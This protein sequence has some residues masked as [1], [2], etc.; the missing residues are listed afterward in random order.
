MP[1]PTRLDAPNLIDL[2]AASADN[3]VQATRRSANSALDGVAAKIETVRGRASPVA[4]RISAPFERVSTY[5]SARPIR[6][7]LAAAA[8]G[9][10]VMAVIGLFT[11]RR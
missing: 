7:L 10:A 6:S 5:A 4:D 9:A 1:T 3:A 2:A 8:T 11:R